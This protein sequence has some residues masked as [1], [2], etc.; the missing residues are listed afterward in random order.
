MNPDPVAETVLSMKPYTFLALALAVVMWG[1]PG[2]TRATQ[3]NEEQLLIAILRSG[4][5][6]AEKDAACARL[7]RI[8]T[9]LSVPALAALLTDEQL[10]HSARYAL[11]SMPSTKAGQ[12]LVDALSK[13]S[14]L[15]KVGIINSL[16]L[17]GE[18]GAVNAL[19]KLLEDPDVQA[20]TASAV[21]LGQIGT[22]RALKALQNTTADSPGPV[23]DAIVKGWLRGANGLLAA[24]S[25]SKALDIFQALYDAETSEAVRTAAYRG[26][27][28]SSGNRGLRLI[29]SSLLGADRAS[30]TAALQSVREVN[31][32]DATKTFGVLLR[33][34][35][36]PI[37]V[38]LIEGL[39]QRGDVS[40]A[41]AVALLVHST[42]PEVRLAAI[43]ALGV[44]GDATMVPLLGVAAASTNA[45]EQAAGRLALVQLHRGN[46]TETM[47]RLLPD[48]KPEV[49]AEFARA[50]GGRADTTAVPR[51]IELARQGP[52]SA[53]KAALQAL[54]LLV[55]D[56]QLGLMVQFVVEARTETSRADAA[57]AL[58]SA[59]QQILTRR[60]KVN[61]EPLRQALASTSIDT[62][63]ALLPVCSGLV[64]P[65]VCTALRAA[66]GSPEPRVHA[67][68]VRAMCDTLDPALLPDVLKLACEAPE[69]SL[70]ILAIRACVRLTTQEEALK[71]PIPQQIETLKTILA[72]RLNNE[73]QR[74]VL[75]GLAAIPDLDALKL[76]EPMLDES[77][78]QS[79]AARAIAMIASA[80][81]YA[82][83]ERAT[84]ALNKVLAMTT[85]PDARKAAA[86]ALKEIRA[87]TG[88][89]VAWQVAGPY[90][91]DGKAYNDLFDIAFP[92]ETGKP[93]EVNWQPL[94]PGPDPK[95]PW[96]MDL[97]KAL[98]G[99]QRVAYA[100][101]C[102]YCD[103][104]Q[105][106][107]LE[108]GTDDGVKVW[109]NQTVVHTN[110]TSRAVQPAADKANVT[111]KA[112]WNPLVLKITR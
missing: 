69:A 96:I 104:E 103:H 77:A 26:M 80:L 22:T 51:L 105:P 99:Q 34:V 81:P 35:G 75:A 86:A 62:R 23:H 90:F 48:A 31:A 42:S 55:E 43:N 15:T 11:E 33:K 9:D 94:P 106:A 59:C 87:G 63:V 45:D 56:S 27:I 5:A 60:G 19:A 93:D 91:Q 65:L 40:A 10:S 13:T 95:R 88:Y 32:P 20:A 7:K 18:K 79:E 8:G 38:G 111:L 44:L 112:G 12:A 76:A 2:A 72:T 24:G 110:N 39:S 57:E 36:P 98:G 84:A 83:A 85:D 1:S 67:A 6:P 25:T 41:P 97:L 107:R 101:T 61:V 92:P 74:L 3:T 30:Q 54:A 82:Q 4:S 68:A 102:V 78:I 58:N 46:P 52:G 37:Q 47:L 49:Q 28:Q 29:P 109:L 66:V 64:D 21:A 70:R 53:S 73:Q 17:R 50:L 89:I 71:L 14:G 16:G 100:R 108:L